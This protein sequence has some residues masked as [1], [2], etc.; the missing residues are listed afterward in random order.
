MEASFLCS[1]LS[2]H[3]HRALACRFL[4]ALASRMLCR[5]TS[6][7]FLGNNQSW[8]TLPSAP[9]AVGEEMLCAWQALASCLVSIVF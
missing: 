8:S 6:K 2:P 9:A 7:P 5:V 1:L 3:S 4:N